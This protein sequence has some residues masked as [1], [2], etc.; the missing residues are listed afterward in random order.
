VRPAQLRGEPLLGILEHARRTTDRYARTLPEDPGT[1]LASYDAWQSIPV[2]ERA[3]LVRERDSFLSRGTPRRWSFSSGTTGTP[4]AV[5]KSERDRLTEAHVSWSHRR[6]HLPRGAYARTLNLFTEQHEGAAA[7][8]PGSDSL[9]DV[10]TAGLRA[11]LPGI[12]D[13]DPEFLWGPASA[14]LRFGR[15]LA[16]TGTRLP[17]LA[18]VESR[19]EFVHP[20]QRDAIRSVIPAVYRDM[21]GM[22]ETGTLA[23]ACEADTLHLID[24][25]FLFEVRRPDGS[26][27]T[28]GSGRLI[29][30]SLFHRAMPVIR[31]LTDDD[32]ELSRN[33]C[34]CTASASG[35]L[36]GEYCIAF[37]AGG[38]TG[39]VLTHQGRHYPLL[40]V[41][42]LISK[43]IGAY[44][45]AVAGSDL[46]LSGFQCVQ[47][48]GAPLTVRIDGVASAR[49]TGLVERAFAATMAGAPVLVEY[50]GDFAIAPS[51]K[52][53][54]LVHEAAR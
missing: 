28:E 34:S 19:G 27:A 48:A 13:H 54:V 24:S 45:A 12:V 33:T 4:V 21:Y 43:L 22:T 35:R 10:S 14:L 20:W 16:E 8:A 50:T 41:T 17:S 52:T 42:V 15:L 47:R 2:Y 36:F 37:T 38:R 3:T 23:Y 32:V 11:A 6:P 39:E 18:L 40:S 7:A 25:R 51:G 9:R 1:Y 44:N 53:P 46:V 49:F 30:T 31:Y 29:V 5:A 26:A